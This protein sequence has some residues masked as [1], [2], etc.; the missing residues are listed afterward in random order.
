MANNPANTTTHKPPNP[1]AMLF[2][3][4]KTFALTGS[5]LTDRRINAAPKAIFIAVIG[6]LLAAAL[7]VDAAAEL[8]SNV[9]PVAGPIVGIPI[10]AVVDW[11]VLSVVA[12]NLLKLFPAQIVGEHYDRLFRSN[13]SKGNP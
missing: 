8:V 10:D 4:V 13:K 12:F 6:V 9:I 3:L 5:L 1:I 11:G 7:G 2:H